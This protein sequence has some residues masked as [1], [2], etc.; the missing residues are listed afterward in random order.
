MIPV[1]KDG[2]QKMKPQK[3]PGLTL[4]NQETRNKQ[5][6]IV[7]SKRGLR[8]AK[9]RYIGHKRINEIRNILTNHHSVL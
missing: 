7:K 4:K 3:P 5:K 1:A 2:C 9:L 6:D 8:F